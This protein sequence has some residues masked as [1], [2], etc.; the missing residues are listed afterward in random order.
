MQDKYFRQENESDVEFNARL[1]AED[2]ESLSVPCPLDSC[3][4]MKGER[5]ATES[6]QPRCRHARR[7]WM[8]RKR[9]E[10]KEIK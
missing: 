3:G 2:L 1:E 4:A 7:L 8:A 6:G 10:R 9:Q 5:C